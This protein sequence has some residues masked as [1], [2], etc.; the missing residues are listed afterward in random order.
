V[1]AR[2]R[3]LTGEPRLLVAVLSRARPLSLARCPVGPI[4]RRQFLS[5]SL[6]LCLAGPDRQPPSRCPERPFPLSL[7]ASWACLVSSAFP[8]LAVDRRVRTSARRRISRPRRPPM[9]PAPFL[10]PR[11]CPA[12]APRLI[13][14]TLTLSRALSSLLDTA[15]DPRPRCR[16]TSSLE[17]APSLP[18]LHPEVRHQSSCPISPIAPCVRPILP[19]PVL[20]RG[21]PPCSRGGRPI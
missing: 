18:E 3:R 5:P 12:L 13:S 6:S 17:T 20:G 7:S 19:L 10:E 2:P 11:Q 9:H 4:Y 8:A 21:G 16:P 14:H 1:P 15:G